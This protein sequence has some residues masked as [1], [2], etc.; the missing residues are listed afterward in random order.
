MPPHGHFERNEYYQKFVPVAIETDGFFFENLQT[1]SYLRPF[2]FFKDSLVS[3][4]T[5][6]FDLCQPDTTEGFVL[7][8]MSYVSKRW[9]YL[10]MVFCPY[11]VPLRYVRPETCHAY[12]I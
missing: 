7:K 2:C 10:S 4:A 5:Q 6:R 11:N 9:Y 1:L 12:N 8:I 3:S